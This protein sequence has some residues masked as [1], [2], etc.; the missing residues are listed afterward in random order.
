MY[1]LKVLLLQTGNRN[2]NNIKYILIL[3]MIS[4]VFLQGR[5]HPDPEPA[6][7]LP[8]IPGETLHYS[9]HYGWING[10][11]ASLRISE[12][13][14]SGRKIHHAK[15]IVKTIG[16]TDKLYKVRDVY[17]SY[18]DVKTGL[19]LKSIRDISESGYKWYNEVK[20]RHSENKVISTRSGEHEVPD[21][22]LDV[23][24]ALY[25]AR[26]ELLNNLKIGDNVRINTFFDDKLYPM[27]IRYL[28]KEK[29]KTKFGKILCLKF[30]PVV[31]VGRVFDTE[32]DLTIWITADKNRIPIRI[33]MDLFLGSVK[34]DLISFSDL[35]YGLSE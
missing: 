16:I 12:L 18:I 20:F 30:L 25:Y 27:T 23:L 29:V 6:V 3:L 8:Y 9:L 2:M 34:C 32:D 10:G 11:L 22:I 28:G 14:V 35:K 19:P 15:A 7:E 24:S 31:E 1:C 21:S 4:C 17:Q 33:Q 13:D 5:D 26:R